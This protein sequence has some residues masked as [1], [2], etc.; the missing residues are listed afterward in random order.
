[1]FGF[2]MF[3]S[4]FC[5]DLQSRP[6]WFAHAS[7]EAVAETALTAEKAV[8]T[9]TAENAVETLAAEKAV[10]TLAAEN[11]AEA[12]TAKKAAETLAAEEAASDAEDVAAPF[13]EDGHAARANWAAQGSQQGH[14]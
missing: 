12:L 10:D 8:E 1:M 6:Y 11:V 14:P 9:L 2:W 7:R 13:I 3:G 4:C 5:P